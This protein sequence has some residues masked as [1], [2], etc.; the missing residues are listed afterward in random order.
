VEKTSNQLL[1]TVCTTNA[2]L[3]LPRKAGE[4]TN[5]FICK[6]NTTFL[7]RMGTLIKIF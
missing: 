5:G 1:Q 7:Y 3:M 2:F 4:L 6:N